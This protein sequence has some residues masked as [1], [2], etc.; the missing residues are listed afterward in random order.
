MNR[1]FLATLSLLAATTTPLLADHGHNARYRALDDM[2]FAAYAEA[3]ELRWE[4]HND[5]V[6]S[7]DYDHL[8]EDADAIISSLRNVQASIYQ[9]RPDGLIARDLVATY[10]KIA[11]LA[12]HLA[13]CDF[14]YVRPARHQVT[15]HGRGYR[16][17]P[18]TRNVGRVHVDA[19]LKMI[20]HVELN[21]DQLAREV[22]L[23]PDHHHGPVPAVAPPGHVP[24]PPQVDDR[25]PR[26]EVRP[27]YSSKVGGVTFSFG[28]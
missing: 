26:G 8:L 16:Y 25:G 18:E 11:N 12:E 24:A 15:F 7:R 3:R 27:V 23:N 20:A 6:A 4:I 2:A 14:A 1:T 17:T 13:G 21:L 22:G 10:Q 9:E 19:A 5:F 28:F